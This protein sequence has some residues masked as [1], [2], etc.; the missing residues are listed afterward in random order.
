LSSN[1][2][3]TTGSPK[4]SPYSPKLPSHSGS[5][6]C[7]NIVIATDVYKQAARAR[8]FDVSARVQCQ[9]GLAAATLLARTVGALLSFAATGRHRCGAWT[10]WH[11]IVTICAA[12]SKPLLSATSASHG[13]RRN[14]FWE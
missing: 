13:H 12:W 4:T 1:V 8:N 7:H 5:L 11:A 14:R 10:V 3:A 2:R 6:E 9:K